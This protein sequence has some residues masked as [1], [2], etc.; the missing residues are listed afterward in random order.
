MSVRRIIVSSWVVSAWTVGRCFPLALA[1]M[2]APD[3][4]GNRTPPGRC[5]HRE[6]A[7]LVLWK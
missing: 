6:I 5:H 2:T 7:V 1:E 4:T 3:H